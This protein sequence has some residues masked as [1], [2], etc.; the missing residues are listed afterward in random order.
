MFNDILHGFSRNCSPNN[1]SS[2]PPIVADLC[3]ELS[4]TYFYLSQTNVT[5]IVS[6]YVTKSFIRSRDYFT[7]KIT[8]LNSMTTDI[9]SI[10][11]TL[12][13]HQPKFFSITF[14]KD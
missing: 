8:S 4:I 9:A 6:H 1:L 12:S 7:K 11:D 13:S 10:E 5:A 14:C 3:S 2:F